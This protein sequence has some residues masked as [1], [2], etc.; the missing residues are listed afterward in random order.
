M[1]FRIHLN[2]L[3]LDKKQRQA[4]RMVLLGKCLVFE[5]HCK[6]SESGPK[7]AGSEVG[8]LSY[9]VVEMMNVLSSVM[10]KQ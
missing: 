9:E 10:G 4:G 7:R 5:Q 8:L 2:I 3:W 1:D 6:T